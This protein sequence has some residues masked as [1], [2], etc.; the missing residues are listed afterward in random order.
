MRLLSS[1]KLFAGIATQL[2]PQTLKAMSAGDLQLS[3]YP[4]AKLLIHD[5]S[6]AF[7]QKNLKEGRDL[8]LHAQKALLD[9]KRTSAEEA[10]SSACL[11]LLPGMLAGEN[12]LA[13]QTM[14]V[15]TCNIVTGTP[16]RIRSTGVWLGADAQQVRWGFPNPNKL[17]GLIETLSSDIAD[18]YSSSPLY[19]AIIAL[20]GINSIHPFLDGNGRTSRA[21]FNA[22]L[23]NANYIPLGS[24][25]P[26]K[27]IYFDA[28]FG[29][30]LRLRQVIFLNEWVPMIDFFCDVM[31]SISEAVA[32]T[33]SCSVDPNNSAGQLMA[34]PK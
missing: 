33:S 19:A 15:K 12:S 17:G 6:E 26:L 9:Q 1:H 31:A 4:S 23:I 11:A 16:Q 14:L 13:L 34:P 27:R 3:H 28:K 7:I 25:I 18:A 21:F 32:A 10:A 20:A 30:E 29:F 5:L 22:I 24:Y 2:L 8:Q